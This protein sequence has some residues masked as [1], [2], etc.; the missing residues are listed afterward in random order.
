MA[1][2]LGSINDWDEDSVC[3]FFANLGYPQFKDTIRGAPGLVV[4]A[5]RYGPDSM[6]RE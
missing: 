3:L 2:P 4:R 1:D 5:R 6:R